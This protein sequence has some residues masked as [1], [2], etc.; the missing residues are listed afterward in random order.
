MKRS[1]SMCALVLAAACTAKS[2]MEES[3]MTNRDGSRASDEKELRPTW[4]ADDAW[5]VR[6]SLLVPSVT[7]T[8]DGEPTWQDEVWEYR[9]QQVSA[10]GGIEVIAECPSLRRPS[11]VLYFNPTG[12]LRS[13]DPPNTEVFRTDDGPHFPMDS[14]WFGK[15][16]TEWPAFP[17]SSEPGVRKFENGELQQWTEHVGDG[18]KVTVERTFSADGELETKTME[19]MW[20]PGRPWWSTM[21]MRVRTGSAG[22]SLEGLEIRGELVTPTLPKGP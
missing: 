14:M 7:K 20:Q 9:V 6:Y 8:T 5:T 17:I 2:G 3:T 19:Q 16:A 1:V 13:I 15:L 11:W 4:N 10:D 21:A 18:W 22:K 12:R